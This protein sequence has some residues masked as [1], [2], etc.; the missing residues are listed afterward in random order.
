MRRNQA[1]MLHSS[2]I[3]FV[4]LRRFASRL[5]C[6]LRNSEGGIVF[7]GQKILALKFA[8]DVVAVTICNK[9]HNLRQLLRLLGRYVMK[10]DL[11]MNAK[12]TKVMVFKRGRR[13][14]EKRWEFMGKKL[15]LTDC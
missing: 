1:G 4:V 10:N 14:R 8:N 7:V 11:E 12:K 9:S 13:A 15:E 6:W 2:S 3:T 5:V